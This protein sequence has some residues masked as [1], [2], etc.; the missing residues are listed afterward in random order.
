MADNFDVILADGTTGV[1]GADNVSSIL[2][3]RVKLQVGDDGTRADV[4]P[5]NPLD[6]LLTNLEKAEDAAHSSGHKGIMALAVRND[7]GTTLAGTDGDY[8]PFGVDANGNLRTILA[9]GTAAV[10]KLAANSGV[11]IGDVDVTS[12]VPGTGAT[13]L[14]KAEDAA[15]V[16]GDTGVLALA[17]RRDTLAAGS[18]TDGDNSTFNVDA[19][20]SLY[21]TNP[22]VYAEDA[23][24]S[25]GDKGLF[26]LGVCK[27]TQAGTSATNDD[28]VGMVFNGVGAQYVQN[29]VHTAGGASTIRLSDIDETEETIKGSAGQLYGFTAINTDTSNPAYIHFYDAVNPDTSVDTPK[30]SFVVPKAASGAPAY[31][32]KEFPFGIPF[33]TAITVSGLT[34]WAPGASGAG[35]D[36]LNGTFEYK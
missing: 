12:I 24:H 25:S 11:D 18:G 27:T 14:G 3:Q 34:T 28:Y 5:S 21:T 29:T 6:V 33:A 23:A 26:M 1:M 7:A 4:G 36:T 2:Y 17:V 35:T 30:M 9:A 15:H 22:A 20:G 31:L 8:A 13:N 16:S 10:G 32:P 19:N